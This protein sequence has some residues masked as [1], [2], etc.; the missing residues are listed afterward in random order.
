MANKHRGEVTLELGGES[1]VLVPSFGNVAEI[2]DAIGTNLL[3]VGKKLEATN[4]TEPELLSFIEA[5]LKASGHEVDAEAIAEGITESGVLNVTAPLIKFV[6]A[7]AFGG[8]TKKKAAGGALKSKA[9][10]RSK[11]TPPAST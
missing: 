9:R 4:F 7:Y 11:K 8:T 1:Y 2:E 5:F 6:V 3:T 10:A